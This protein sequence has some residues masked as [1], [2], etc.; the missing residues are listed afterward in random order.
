MFLHGMLCPFHAGHNEKCVL[1]KAMKMVQQRTCVDFIEIKPPY[2]VYSHYVH[3][4][5]TTANMWVCACFTWIYMIAFCL[6]FVL[7]NVAPLLHTCS[8][9][10]QGPGLFTSSQINVIQFILQFYLYIHVPVSMHVQT[11]KLFTTTYT[12]M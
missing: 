9:S 12:Y 3:F 1:V 11:C 4:I 10:G 7:G 5:S 2:E 6:R 8:K